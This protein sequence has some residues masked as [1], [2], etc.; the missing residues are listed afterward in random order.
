LRPTFGAARFAACSVPVA[1]NSLSQ[2]RHIFRLVGFDTKDGLP[3]VPLADRQDF[4][5]A[6][7]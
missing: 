4:I 3:A 7:H 6:L 1:P 2:I 5:R